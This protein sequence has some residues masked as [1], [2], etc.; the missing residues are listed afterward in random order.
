MRIS[1]CIIAITL[2]FLSCNKDKTT[3]TPTPYSITIP[4]H[5]PQME[6]PLD[7]PMTEEGI[8]LGRH[9]FYEKKLSGDNTMSCSSCHLPENAFAENSQ[10]STGIDGISGNRNAMP[11]FNLGW[12]EFFFWDGRK[13]TL[14]NQI[15]D[16]LTRCVQ[17]NVKFSPDDIFGNVDSQ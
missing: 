9:L 6:I 8:E 4:T 5:F 7:N 13:N 2:L 14:E 3:Y 10:F 16:L 17:K 11:L 15:L 1:F 12:E